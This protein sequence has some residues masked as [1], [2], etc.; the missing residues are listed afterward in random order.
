MKIK[1][2]SKKLFFI[3][4]TYVFH[5]FIFAALPVLTTL[6]REINWVVGTEAIRPLML[7]IFASATILFALRFVLKD[8]PRAGFLTSLLIIY[9]LHYGYSYKLP[10][11]TYIGGIGVNRHAII[12][13][14]WM[15]VLSVVGSNMVWRQVR[16]NVI[17]NFMNLLSVI[18][19]IFP[20]RSIII[21]LV[22]V[23][24]DPLTGWTP[25]E[26]HTKTNPYTETSYKPD[27]YYIILDGYAREDVLWEIFQFDNSSFIRN[28][29]EQGFYVGAQ[30]K[31]NYIQTS[32]SLASSMNFEYLD[33]FEGVLS[34]NRYPMRDLVYNSRARA[35]LNDLGYQMVAVSSEF[36]V[37][38]IRNA[39]IYLPFNTSI[40]SD[41][42][43]AFLVSTTAQILVDNDRL[44]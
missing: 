20:L 12:F 19:L 5:P 30:S 3:R 42:E 2:I 22:A 10:L 31:T 26:N 44:D 1:K 8:W 21:F 37:T 17:T 41:F 4:R 9:L 38:D 29:E 23:N 15:I 40:I 6:A 24:N 34:A 18:Y 25:V 16:P 14:A 36:L 27:I 35:Y 7:S 11:T 32:L 33:A 43:G 13:I 39:D 28:L